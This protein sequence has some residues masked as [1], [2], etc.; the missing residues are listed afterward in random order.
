M[1]IIHLARLTQ[2]FLSC[3]YSDFKISPITVFAN[4]YFGKFY[5][6]VKAGLKLYLPTKTTS[7][8][9]PIFVMNRWDYFRS[10]ATF[11]E[12]SKPSFLVQNETFWSVRYKIPLS[13]KSTLVLTLQMVLMKMIIIR[14]MTLRNSIRQITR[15][16]CITLRDWNLLLMN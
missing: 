2:G 9:E 7:Y 15:V 13:T 11:F 6:S 5:G 16:F 8:I 4:T 3:S 12:D 1:G 10:F 14:L